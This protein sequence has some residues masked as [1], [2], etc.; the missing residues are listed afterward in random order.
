MLPTHDQRTAPNNLAAVHYS[1]LYLQDISE[2]GGAWGCHGNA[3]YLS[4]NL[5]IHLSY[6]HLHRHTF[7]PTPR[8]PPHFHLHSMFQYDSM[9]YIG[10]L[11]IYAFFVV[12]T[13]LNKFIMGPV[14][15]R[16]FLQERQEGDFRYVLFVTSLWVHL[17]L[18]YMVCVLV[19]VA[20]IQHS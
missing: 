15:S 13:V 6:A 17:S 8:P 7:T 9:G 12:S 3:A 18:V 16:V 20:W 10:P 19:L 4:T 14:V 1:L 5:C 11:S 2:V